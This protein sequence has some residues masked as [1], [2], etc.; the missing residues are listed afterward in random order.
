MPT[1]EDLDSHD[2]IWKYS[3]RVGALRGDSHGGGYAPEGAY[4]EDFE[5]DRDQTS[6]EALAIWDALTDEER[7]QIERRAEEKILSDD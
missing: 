2:L 4:L 5:I 1:P 7:E 3:S 6:P